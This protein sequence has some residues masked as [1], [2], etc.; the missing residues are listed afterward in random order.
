[1]TYFKK[2]KK[3]YGNLAVMGISAGVTGAI[4]SKAGVGGGIS[5]GVSTAASFVPIGVTATMGGSVLNQV[6]K[7]NKKKKKRR[8]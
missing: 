2:S 4:V 1:M 8:R 6:R 7:L 3:T 5:Q